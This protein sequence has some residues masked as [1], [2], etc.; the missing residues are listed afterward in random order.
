M[1][2][3]MRIDLLG[4]PIK[5]S[6]VHPGFIRSEINEKVKKVPFIVDTETGCKAM[7]KAI[8]KE[9]ENSYVPS[10]PWAFLQLFLRIAPKSILKKMS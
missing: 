1:S 9:G 10:W 3:G 2:E 8:E 6:T 5:V 7:V 4:T